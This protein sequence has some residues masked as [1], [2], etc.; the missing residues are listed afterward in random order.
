[1]VVTTTREKIA[2]LR[3][4]NKMTQEKLAELLCV[5]RSTVTNWELGI[6]K[7]D[8]ESLLKIA[9][10]FSVTVDY[11]LGNELPKHS[12]I[13]KL[14]EH[15]KV[16]PIEMENRRILREYFLGMLKRKGLTSASATS[17]VMGRILTASEID[18]LMDGE[19]PRFIEK[20]RIKDFFYK[21]PPDEVIRYYEIADMRVPDAFINVEMQIKEL[22]DQLSLSSDGSTEAMEWAINYFKQ[23]YEAAVQKEKIK[24]KTTDGADNL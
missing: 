16:P 5:G 7:L 13:S 20:E 6:N 1:M 15:E 10:I 23:Q 11:L 4:N 22:A 17:A 9:N 8:T 24:D 14:A 19:S 12:I 18:R 21:F 2:Q 3:K